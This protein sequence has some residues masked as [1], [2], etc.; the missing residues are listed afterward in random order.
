[1]FSL[2]SVHI[3]AAMPTDQS[4]Q[5]EV[6][7]LRTKLEAKTVQ[8][9]EQAEQ[10]KEFKKL[11]QDMVE[12]FKKQADQYQVKIQDMENQHR[13]KIQDM[14]NQHRVQI[15]DMQNQHQVQ[16]QEL[17]RE[18]EGN[19]LMQSTLF[20]LTGMVCTA[21]LA[22]SAKTVVA[23][24]IND[25]QLQSLRGKLKISKSF[26]VR[27]RFDS[28]KHTRFWCALAFAAIDMSNI[29]Y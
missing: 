12:Q 16:V 29:A 13:V 5:A 14:E 23:S 24:K 21:A 15:Q 10:L 4:V 27:Q 25:A 6:Q 28:S 19:L 8:Q 22:E 11:L 18:L 20:S 9:E 1:M 3:L 7:D 17:L 26:L 2:S